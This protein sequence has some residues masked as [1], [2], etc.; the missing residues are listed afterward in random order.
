MA[1]GCGSTPCTP[2]YPVD[3]ASQAVGMFTYVHLPSP[4]LFLDAEPVIL[5]DPA[6]HPTICHIFKGAVSA[7]ARQ[8]RKNIETFKLR[9]VFA[10]SGI[11]W[12][13]VKYRLVPTH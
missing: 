11:T 10:N 6:R 2:G 13:P 4:T 7:P 8:P 1:V 3:Q 12:H 9:Q 5:A